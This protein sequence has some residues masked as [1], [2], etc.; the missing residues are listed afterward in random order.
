MALF[1]DNGTKV[2][3]PSEIKPSL[4][5]TNISYYLKDLSL[6]QQE[7]FRVFIGFKATSTDYGHTMA[8]SL[9]LCGPNSNS[10]PNPK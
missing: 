10:N 7:V 4:R 5:K 8:K 6:I 2:K 9:I 1:V 3:I